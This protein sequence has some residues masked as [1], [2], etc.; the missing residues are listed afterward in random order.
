MAINFAGY[1]YKDN[2]DP[3]NG[4]DV[5]LKQVS[6][7]VTEASTTTDSNG[8]WAFSESDEDRYYVEIA[9]GSSKR[10]IRWA[11]EISL[12]EI[13][14]RNNE[15]NT[16]PAATFTNL[17]NNA[18]NDVVH[19]RSLRGTGAD[20][21]E[22]FIRYYMD[23]ASSNT[24]EVAR[25]TVKLISASAA[26]EDSEIRWGV[27]V[28]G[29]IVDVLTISNT[30]AGATDMTMDV[31]GDISLDADGG[32]VFF[33]DGGTTFGSATNSS[34]NLILKSGTTTAATFSGANVTFAGTVDATTDFTIGDT[35]IT[36][37]VVTDSTGLQLAANL[38]INGTADISGDLT[39]S[40]GADGALQF[41]NAGE[42][43]IKIPDNQASALIIEEADNA[44]ITFV[45]SNGSEAITV[46]KATTFSAGIANAGTIGAGTWNGTAIASSY[47]AADAITGA[48]IA[49]DAIDSEHYTDGSID[50]AHL[51]ADAVTGA[52]I[53]DDAIDSEHYT[54]GS[55][56]NAHLADD[57]VGA[58]E[59]AANAVVDASVASGAAI[60]VSKLALT[61]G[62]G[63]TLNTNDID[64]DASLTTV[65]SIT[66]ASLVV[67][68][69]ADNDIDF[70][71]DNNIRFRAGGEDQLTLTDGALTPSSNAIVD[72]G[73]DAL[74][75]KDAYFDG[76]LEADAITIG[77]TNIV[78]GEVITTLGTISAGTWEGTDVAVA[79][80]G[81]GASSLTD[82]GV[83]LGS[84]TDAVT[85]MAVLADGEM[86]VGDGTTDPVA[87]SGA[88]LRTSIGVGTG[89]SPQFTAIELGHASDT[90]IAR[91]GSGAITVEGTQVLLAGAQTGVTTIL[92]ASTKIGRDSDNLVDF[93]TTDNKII[94]RV[95]GVNEVELVQ[96]ALSPV[97]S[98]GVALGTSSL[99]WSDLFV[100]S[101]GVV[102]FNNGDVT[103]THASDTLTL[104]GGQ[105]LVPD[106]TAALPSVSND[107]DPNTG[108][109]FPAADSVAWSA[110]GTER[111]RM[112]QYGLIVTGGEYTTSQVPMDDARNDYDT[113]GYQ[114]DVG[115]GLMG[116]EMHLTIPTGANTGGIAID[117]QTS[118]KASRGQLAFRRGYST[119]SALGNTGS[120]TEFGAISWQQV[121]VPVSG[122]T[123]EGYNQ[124]A[125]IAKIELK[126]SHS[127]ASTARATLDFYT[128][129]RG[130][131]TS[132]QTGAA[133]YAG[134]SGPELAMRINYNQQVEVYNS[135]SIKRNANNSARLQIYDTDGSH[136]NSIASPAMTA[137]VN[138]ILPATDG[139]NTQ[140]LQ[141]DGSANLTWVS[142]SS[143][144]RYKEDIKP[145][146]ID[147]SKIYELTPKSFKFIEGHKTSLPG[148]F[149]YIAEEVEKILPELVLYDKENR[150]DA[151]MYELLTVL[152]LE[153]VKK[154]RSMITE[155]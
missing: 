112:D 67:G 18:D 40:G 108:M 13:D 106:G 98:D 11:D 28:G 92:N 20:N 141:T 119:G 27:A 10:F 87:E 97:T 103:L 102:N 24:T 62:D 130:G 26:S 122:Q 151:L 38:D 63:L 82:G 143:S 64:L 150:P 80:G 117:T 34:G 121:H 53:A 128:S 60:A 5:Y 12:K 42:N 51:A 96:N 120:D 85:A 153:E 88:T 6:D 133:Y 148:E 101:G 29:S 105:L 90:T 110:G 48:K 22:M 81:T 61:A 99:M 79:H 71:T 14:V 93:A 86:I 113:N 125:E 15:A 126:G 46:A 138:Y 35:V 41:T 139:S 147:S 127:V 30:D 142:A 123:G 132:T 1:V 69:D 124:L 50:T 23:D 45:T 155:E 16:T 33:K 84:G 8:Y 78:T 77:G 52:K 94:F 100:A 146:E 152:L 154:L 58:D 140:Q 68:R 55:I 59:L 44:Y 19:F 47:I 3:V 36:D 131:D 17:T 135:L 136:Y 70:T 72:L 144:L 25:M 32:D 145:L 56:D 43:S 4:A 134:V 66:N 129:S 57:A 75:F 65:T 118:T 89:D 37:G 7:G 74:E 21:D 31:A 114:D 73:T 39:L 111:M 91:S 49:D 115:N 107:G 109:N 95:E 149:G 2:G 104:A 116:K 76:T 54:D 83:L 137:N 9:S